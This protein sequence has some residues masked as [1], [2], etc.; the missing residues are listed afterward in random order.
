MTYTVG[1]V[2]A[3]PSARRGSVLAEGTGRNR[4]VVLKCF[5]LLL[6]IEEGCRIN[7]PLLS[8]RPNDYAVSDDFLS[9]KRNRVLEYFEYRSFR[10]EAFHA[11]YFRNVRVPI[12]DSSLNSVVFVISTLPLNM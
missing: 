4:Q 10:K 6:F 1:R 5:A 11:G 8:Q 12:L 3:G 9:S 7:G 2:V